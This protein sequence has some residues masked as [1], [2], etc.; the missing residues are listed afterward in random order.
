MMCFHF[1]SYA[2]L[3][4]CLI[5]LYPRYSLP[6]CWLTRVPHFLL[7]PSCTRLIAP[8]QCVPSVV[9][10]SLIPFLA[11]GCPIARFYPVFRRSLVSIM[12]P[13][14]LNFLLLL[15]VTA[16]GSILSC[17]S[18]LDRFSRVYPPLARFYC[19]CRP[20]LCFIA[21]PAACSILSCVSPLAQFI[22]T[23]C[24]WPLIYLVMISNFRTLPGLSFY[25]RLPKVSGCLLALG[26]RPYLMIVG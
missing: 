1:H 6:G 3:V 17:V 16:T 23:Y 12:Y 2:L 5:L 21:S 25:F 8:F 24:R 19:V 14:S 20:S 10:I 11:V 4:S 13:Y 7:L 9:W 26:N 22:K 15:S 18:L